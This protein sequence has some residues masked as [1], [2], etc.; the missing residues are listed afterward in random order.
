MMNLA[1]H[2]QDFN[3]KAAWTFTSS[4]HG[5]SPCDGLGAVVKSG[6]RKDLLK[7]GPEAAFCLAKD[8]YQF[9]L[10]KTSRILYTVKSGSSTK[11]TNLPIDEAKEE[12][13][14]EEIDVTS[15]RLNR[16]I[17]VRWIGEEEVEATFQRVLKKRWSTLST[18]SNEFIALNFTIF[19]STT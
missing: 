6:A 15:S 14:D 17:E 5:R 12:S 1:L 11:S 4:G 3:I 18:K 19:S 8:F 13:T 2:L 7:K 10:E 16:S 9:T